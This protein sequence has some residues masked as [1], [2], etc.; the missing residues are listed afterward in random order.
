MFSGA[1]AVGMWK[2]GGTADGNALPILPLLHSH[3]SLD[4]T[5]IMQI[6]SVLGFQDPDL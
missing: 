6:A 3:P 1:K 2:H 5:V 4:P